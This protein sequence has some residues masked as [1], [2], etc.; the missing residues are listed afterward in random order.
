MSV[1][2]P[3]LPQTVMRLSGLLLI[4]LA[5]AVS[6]TPASA[7][8]VVAFGGASGPG[9]ASMSFNNLGTPTPG[10]DDVAGDSPNWIAVNQK[11]FGSVGYIDMV[12][13]V[14]DAGIPTTEYVL[15]EGVHNGTGIDWTD[16]H[17]ELGF[18]TGAG[19]VPSG[20][21]D[22]LDFDSPDMNS[23][24]DFAPFGS[25]T[26]GEDTIDAVG[27]PFPNGSFHV[28]TFPIDVPGGI[29]EFTIRQY[30]TIAPVPT[31]PIT[32]GRIKSLY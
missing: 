30:P 9:L 28:I 11:A 19:F 3:P 5:V 14:D 16:Y 26:V 10:N 29:T 1:S 20:P 24:Y 27:G 22:G 6:A 2:Y 32:W 13:I 21:G 15:T 17:L 8:I 18:G 25:P 7:Q 12:F 31:L 4:A 23:T